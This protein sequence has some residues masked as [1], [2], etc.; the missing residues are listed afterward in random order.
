MN[1]P[2]ARSLA[3]PKSAGANRQ[4]TMP[5]VSAVILAGG[6][7]RRLGVDK[8]LLKLDGEWL[9]ERIANALAS[10]SDDLLVVVDDRDKLGHLGLRTVADA[11]PGLGPL[12]GIYSGL[13]AMRHERGLFVA[14]DMPLLN[15]GLLRYMVSLSSD[16][17]VVIPRI[18]DNVE[19]LHAVYSKVCAMP[20]ADLLEQGDLR[21]VHF[22]SQVRVRY[23]EQTEIDAYDPQH[24]SF[25]NINTADDLERARQLIHRQR[26]SRSGQGA[27]Q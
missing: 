3:Q 25:F 18:G 19:P 4:P 17:D 2:Q 23:V 7:S 27:D 12:G 26:G 15:A 22:F 11:R 13:Q 9:L 5:E 8:A 24:W 16:F 10:L 6:R 14:C 1:N 20:V 21:I